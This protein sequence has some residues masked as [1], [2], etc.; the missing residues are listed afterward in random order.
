MYDKNMFL[1]LH[2]IFY[3]ISILLGEAVNLIWDSS[4]VY[5]SG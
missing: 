5:I 1:G 4:E 3:V 2:F